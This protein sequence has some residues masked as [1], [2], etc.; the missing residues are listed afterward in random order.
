METKSLITTEGLK[1]IGDLLLVVLK[2]NLK[3]DAFLSLESKLDAIRTE[4]RSFPLRMLF[5][6]VP[7][8][9]GKQI[10]F[11]EAKELAV[12]SSFLPENTFHGWTLERLCRVWVLLQISQAD[13]ICYLK[14]INDLFESAEMNEQVALYSALPFLIYPEEWIFRCEEG[15]RSNI[16]LIL[17]A[18]MYYNPYPAHYL[19]E[20]AWNQM[21]L[22]AFFTDK[23]VNHIIGLHERTNARLTAS[24]KDYI[25]ERLAAH[26]T[27]NDEIYKLLV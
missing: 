6:Q 13:K 7:R 26:R 9:T 14:M 19:S 10:V 27:V 16:G 8:L 22:K 20:A 4:A 12:I 11:L 1:T 15:I 18:I 5:A 24:L 3:A 23:N 25:A 17:E 21:I 2:R